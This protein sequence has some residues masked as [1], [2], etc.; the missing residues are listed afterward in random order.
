MVGLGTASCF[1]SIHS[2][3]TVVQ[4]PRPPE[5]WSV[6]GTVSVQSLF[7]GRNTRPER[8]KAQILSASHR[9]HSHLRTMLAPLRPMTHSLPRRLRRVAV[10]SCGFLLLVC[11]FQGLFLL[12]AQHAHASCVLSLFRST[13]FNTAQNPSA[14]LAA[15]QAARVSGRHRLSTG[16]H[17]AGMPFV[18]A[19]G[20][21][22]TSPSKPRALW[23]RG[24][25]HASQMG[26]GL[27]ISRRDNLCN[28]HNVCN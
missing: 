11:A 12:G 13:S 14:P 9:N 10:D 27:P 3:P 21:A 2:R 7:L 18:T 8:V 28:R 25:I 4:D 20:V 19:I 6:T 17:V 22:R 5:V 26:S 16:R 1:V 15:L 24:S 23:H